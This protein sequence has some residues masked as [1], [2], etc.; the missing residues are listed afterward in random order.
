[1]NESYFR[2]GVVFNDDRSDFKTKN[3]Q[4]SEQAALQQLFWVEDLSRAS[5]NKGDDVYQCLGSNE[6]EGRATH[7]YFEKV[8]EGKT[9]KR[10]RCPCRT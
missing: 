5:P 7:E 4:F 8:E 9:V 6:A 1:M 2:E 10:R 3:D